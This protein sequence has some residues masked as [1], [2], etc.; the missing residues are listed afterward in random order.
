MDE[1]SL[2]QRLHRASNAGSG[3]LDRTCEAAA[4]ESINAGEQPPFEVDSADFAGDDPSLITAYRHWLRL[5]ELP[6][7]DT[8]APGAAND[9]NGASPRNTVPRTGNT[10]PETRPRPSAR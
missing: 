3:E 2:E 5:F 9:W 7:V 10:A 4:H 6:T 8:A 1:Q